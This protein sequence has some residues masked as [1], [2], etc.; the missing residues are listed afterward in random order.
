MTKELIKVVVHSKFGA[1]PFDNVFCFGV[2]SGDVAPTSDANIYAAVY[3][4]PAVT[5]WDVWDPADGDYPADPTPL[6][7]IVGFLTALR[8]IDITITGATISDGVADTD[9]TYPVSIYQQGTRSLV[10]G[11]PGSKAPGNIV[12]LIGKQ[13]VE[14]GISFGHIELRAALADNE[15][16]MSGDQLLGW[17]EGQQ[18]YALE[19][20]AAAIE[21]SHIDKY[22][23]LEPGGSTGWNLA[24]PRAY[25]AESLHPGSWYDCVSVKNFTFGEPKSRQVSRGKK[26]KKVTP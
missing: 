21:A 18:V 9:K 17:T 3:G 10:V 20:L 14:L 6:Q 11:D 13:P 26:K 2:G 15:I 4:N 5:D 7:A 12:W 24:I 22:F 19:R 25:D 16:S 8:F 1:K 23:A